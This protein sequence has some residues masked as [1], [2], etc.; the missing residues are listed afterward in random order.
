M[1]KE[2]VKPYNYKTRE[3][4]YFSTKGSSLYYAH[5]GTT[6]IPLRSYYDELW[7]SSDLKSF[8]SIRIIRQTK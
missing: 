3:G 6:L 4:T 5:K 8:S 1:K 2:L 7:D